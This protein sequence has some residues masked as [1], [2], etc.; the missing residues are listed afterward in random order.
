MENRPFKVP[1]KLHHTHLCENARDDANKLGP[2]RLPCSISVSHL[3]VFTP[4]WS[5][6]FKIS[7]RLF[8]FFFFY[9]PAFR[10]AAAAAVEPLSIHPAFL[11]NFSFDWTPGQKINM[12]KLDAE[13]RPPSSLI[14]DRVHKSL[15]HLCPQTSWWWRQRVQRSSGM[16]LWRK[17]QAGSLKTW[18]PLGYLP[19]FS[20]SAG[21]ET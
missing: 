4:H 16:W 7:S 18:N 9:S 20:L 12:R 8:F 5:D 21:N 13:L 14:R 6:G 2:V 19:P 10:Q 11:T 17:N 15:K 1:L 3:S